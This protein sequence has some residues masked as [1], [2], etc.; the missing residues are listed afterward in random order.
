M[1]PDT[2]YRTIARIAQEFD[3]FFFSIGLPEH[4]IIHSIPSPLRISST[5]ACRLGFLAQFLE[6]G[7]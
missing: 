7:N 2:K 5:E 1:R 3:K 6:F 4:T